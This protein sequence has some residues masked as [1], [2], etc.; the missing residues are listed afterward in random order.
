MRISLNWL[1]EFIEFDLPAEELAH[2]LTMLGLEIEAIDQPG[3]EISSVYVGQL[4]SIE[5]HPD[6]DKLVVCRTQVGPGEPL[7]IVCGAKNMK[8]GDKVPTAVVGGSLPGGFAIGKRKMRGIESHGMM[9]SARE[10]GLGE[11]HAGLL[12]LPEDAPVGADA[13]AYLGLDDTVLEI[14]VT[15]NRG[16]WASMAGVARELGAH[17][18]RPFHMPEFAVRE[19]GK[20]AADCSSV[21]IEN[22]DLCG[23]YIGRILTGVKVGPSPAWLCQRLVAA[24]QRPVNNIVDITNYVLLETG[25]PLHAFD[26]AKLQE[27]RIV[28]RPARS[29]ERLTTIDHEDRALNPDMLVIADA[30]APVAIAGVMGGLDSEVGEATQSVF[31]ESAVFNPIS[32]RRTARALGMQTEASQRFQRGADPEMALYAINRAAALMQE[33]AGAQIAPGLLDEYPHVAARKEVTLRYDRADLV[34]G[35]SVAPADQREILARLGFEIV[36]EDA[37]SCTVAVP[38]WRH[39]VKQECDLIE[40]VARLHGYDNMDVS[41]PAVRQSDAVHAPLDRR[42]RELRHFLVGQGLTEMLHWTFTSRKRIGAAGLGDAF[43]DAVALQNPLSDNYGVLRTSLL[44]TMLETVAA[45]IRRGN[46]DV[47][48]FEIGPA[49]HPQAGQDLPEQ[50]TMLAIALS[51]C[52]EAR[53]WSHPPRQADFY[54]LKGRLEALGHHLGVPCVLEETSTALFEDGQ[55]ATL[56]VDGHTLGHLGRVSRGVAG[57]F[58]LTQPVYLLELDLTQVLTQFAPPRAIFRE[59]ANFPA[60]LRDMALLVNTDVPAGTLIGTAR[61]AG[62]TLLKHVGVFDVYTGKQVPDNKKSVALEFVFQS[63]ERTLTD[64][65][66]QKAWDNILKALEKEHGAQLR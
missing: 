4:V 61:S 19:A 18:R 20:P 32:I 46:T 40:E 55:S 28:V 13:A 21:T 50:R 9:C 52:L 43:L 64:E 3:K 48:A 10:L 30:K 54:D 16:D 17:L 6:A 22:P 59:P 53:H 24:G 27:T 60:S 7:Q 15:P 66:T 51:G 35:T 63:H 1:R 41:V 47:A 31:L 23:R 2:Q 5:P 65:D 58:D 62:G 38:T 39:D 45:N 11:D 57:E 36:R 34:L 44:P 33:I 8:V 49:Y 56:A 37:Q 14:E 42:I 12:I 26:L 29:G 25:H